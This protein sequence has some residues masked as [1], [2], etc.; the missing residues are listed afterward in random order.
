MVLFY[1][2]SGIGFQNFPERSSGIS[3]KES[4]G[5]PEEFFCQISRKP[6]QDFPGKKYLNKV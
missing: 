3:R 4:S 6:C 5:I 2:F 1:G